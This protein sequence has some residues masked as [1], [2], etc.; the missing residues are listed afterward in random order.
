MA[1]MTVSMPE[2]D[3]MKVLTHLADVPFKQV[4][5]LIHNMQR[6]LQMQAEQNQRNLAPKSNGNG[7]HVSPGA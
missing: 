7:E 5:P 4:A 2:E 6:Q 3:W 1:D